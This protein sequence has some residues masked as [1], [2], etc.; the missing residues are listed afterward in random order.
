MDKTGIY[1]VTAFFFF[2]VTS[3]MSQLAGKLQSCSIEGERVAVDSIV[4]GRCFSCTCKNGFVWCSDGCPKTDGCH[5]LVQEEGCCKRCKG[6]IHNGV[7][8]AS[9]TEWQ[10]RYSPC[11]VMRCE[12][13]VVT[14]SQ[15]RCF[16][17]C[18]NPLPPEPGKCCP[19]CPECKIND[20][21][22]TEDREVTLDDPCLKCR[23]SA[24]KMTCSK[25][26]CPVLQCTRQRQFDPPGECCP[27]CRGTRTLIPP[28]NTCTL[29]TSFFRDGDTF[30]TDKCT[31][32]TCTNDTSICRRPTCPILDCTPELQIYPKGSCCKVCQQPEESRSSCYHNEVEYQDGQQWK[33]DACKSC[34]CQRGMPS[35]VITR[36]NTTSIACSDGTRLVRLPGECCQK[37]VEVEAACMVFGDPHYKTFDGRIYSFKGVGKYQLVADCSDN[38][39]SIRV[40]N[41]LNQ[42]SSSLT[43]R[44]AI[45]YLNN[46]INLQQKGR[47]KY[48]GTIIKLP[49]KIEGK[50]HAEKKKENSVEITL[51]NG[52]K[53]F[54]NFRSFV[55]VVVPPAF[56][57]KVCGLCGNF[58][59]AVQDDLRTKSGRVLSDKEVLAFGASWCIGKKSE[60]GKKVR[61]NRPA[62]PMKKNNCKMFNNDTFSACHSKLNFSK[63]YRA[64]KMDMDHCHK[65][66]NCYCD[67]LMAYARECNRLGAELGNWQKHTFCDHNS[68]RRKKKRFHKAHRRQEAQLL[69]QLPKMLNRTRSSKS[70][71]GLT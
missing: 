24:G 55:E 71:V 13:G 26:A 12:A 47:I 69:R 16:T 19:T 38:T 8:H 61:Q 28:K 15:L 45:K 48:N 3:A 68:L 27:I 1:L 33:L 11:T 30:N 5:L 41:I 10:D 25:K 63:Y 46:R 43:K 18:A 60:C 67:S 6:C 70:P 65:G 62:K 58:N 56:K 39:F 44:V 51:N 2:S 21:I 20:Q 57:N 35:C 17:P 14:V 64:C 4:K 23:C 29:Q 37:C 36:C 34:I 31:N 50:F 42:S 9:D 49:F 52:V 66:Y 22:V 32:C 40:A 7:Y 54:W 59:R 53:I